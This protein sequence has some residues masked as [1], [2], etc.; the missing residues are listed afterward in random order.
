MGA[1]TT[2]AGWTTT[3]IG[4]GAGGGGVGVV[5]GGGALH[6]PRC[7]AV[8]ADWPPGHCA[9]ARTVAPPVPIGAVSDEMPA[10]AVPDPTNPGG[11]AAVGTDW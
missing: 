1:N 9:Y 3:A 5:V 11:L 7:A 6:G 8:I 2:G 4:G 10:V